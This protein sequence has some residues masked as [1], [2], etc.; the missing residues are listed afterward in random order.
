MACA[1]HTH[2]TCQGAVR[3]KHSSD[4]SGDTHERTGCVLD[5]A[6]GPRNSHDCFALHPRFAMHPRPRNQCSLHLRRLLLFAL[7]TNYRQKLVIRLRH[8]EL[9]K[10]PALWNPLSL[11]LHGKMQR[12][13]M[14]L[15]PSP[16]ICFTE[17]CAYTSARCASLWQ[18]CAPG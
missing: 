12:R 10:T 5:A 13:A 6:R 9:Q 15:I 18:V 11:Q 4:A 16:T 1:W 17:V 8:A 2:A 14:T 3:G 7:I